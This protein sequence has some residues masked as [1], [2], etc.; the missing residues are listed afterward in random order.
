[1]RSPR[2]SL[3]TGSGLYGDGEGFPHLH[4]HAILR[5]GLDCRTLQR[6]HG[7]LVDELVARRLDD[8]DIPDDT[9]LVHERHEERRSDGTVGRARD[10]SRLRREIAHA[11]EPHEPRLDDPLPR[12]HAV[13][14]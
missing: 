5:R 6:A 4:L 13:A 7:G 1:M 2:K 14:L 12:A 10:L 3:S 11:A 8:P 9:A